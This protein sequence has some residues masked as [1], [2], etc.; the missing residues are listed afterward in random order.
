V[1]VHPV[2]FKNHT[3]CTF[4]LPKSQVRFGNIYGTLIPPPQTMDGKKGK[5]LKDGKEMNQ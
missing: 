5:G 4:F 1:K 3:G 2:A